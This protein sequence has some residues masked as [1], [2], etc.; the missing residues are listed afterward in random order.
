MFGSRLKSLRESNGLTKEQLANKAEIARTTLYK[1]EAG[2][3]DPKLSTLNRIFE[4]LEVNF[5][6]F[7]KMK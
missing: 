7:L 3:A 6:E 4:V 1:I 2:K 5:L